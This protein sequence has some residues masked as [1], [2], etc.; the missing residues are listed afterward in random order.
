MNPDLSLSMLADYMDINY[1]YLSKL[2]RSKMEKS[3]IEYLT[4]VRMNKALELLKKGENNVKQ[5]AEL[6]GYLDDKYF[7]RSFKKY[8]NI[9]PGACLRKE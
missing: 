1:H 9:T 5:V 7:N 3:F 4:D 8:F 2:F 6:V